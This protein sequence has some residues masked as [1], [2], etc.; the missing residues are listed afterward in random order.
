[1]RPSADISSCRRD[2]DAFTHFLMSGWS[3]IR[4][5]RAPVMLAA[6]RASTSAEG[7]DTPCRMRA[8]SQPIHRSRRRKSPNSKKKVSTAPAHA[9]KVPAASL[10]LSKRWNARSKKPRLCAGET[11]N[12]QAPSQ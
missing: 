7:K 2:N 4:H 8:S 1:M 11:H 9:E 5:I 12:L 10:A 3:G 6:T